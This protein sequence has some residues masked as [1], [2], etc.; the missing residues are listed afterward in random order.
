MRNLLLSAALMTGVSGLA[1][2]QVDT[3][4]PGTA[5]GA[6]PA[7]SADACVATCAGDAA[8]A[9]WNFV[10]LRPGAAICEFLRDDAAPAPSPGSVSGLSPS[11]RPA[12]SRLVRSATPSTVRIGTPRSSASRVTVREAP[13]HMK[14]PHDAAH[15]RPVAP[16]PTPQP[17]PQPQQRTPAL[18]H[19]L[20]ARPARP[21]APQAMP[22][23]SQPRTGAGTRPP[24]GQPIARATAAPTAPI[25]APQAHATAPR[26]PF[27]RPPAPPSMSAHPPASGAHAGTGPFAAPN[28]API[29]QPATAPKLTSG[30][31]FGHLFDDIS[32]APAP[33]DPKT[34]ADE[35]APVPTA[36]PSL[37]KGLAGG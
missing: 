18:Q 31:L 8:C 33:A 9:A 34:L 29:A 21:T 17:L 35:G 36:A 11:H 3:Y 1:H 30:N 37:M 2:A 6:V 20:D 16:A 22:P 32:A 7:Q 23:H 14:V 15:R 19:M 12:S 25:P 13:P 24:I 5:Y 10:Q 27:A 26:S 28:P 4:R